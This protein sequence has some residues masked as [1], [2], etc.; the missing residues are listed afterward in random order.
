MLKY[1]IINHNNK[2][3]FS[4]FNYYVHIFKGLTRK[5]LV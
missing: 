4:I 1:V 2:V 5:W 3:D